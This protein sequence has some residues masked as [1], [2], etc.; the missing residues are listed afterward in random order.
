MIIRNPIPP[1]INTNN[2]NNNNLYEYDPYVIKDDEI[3]IDKTWWNSLTPY[4]QI[5][6]KTSLDN[7]FKLGIIKVPHNITKDKRLTYIYQAYLDGFD[8]NVW[9]NNAIPNGP[10]GVVNVPEGIS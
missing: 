5:L 9:Y 6:I 7:N 10:K 1:N 2:Y 3:V 8:Y 4:I